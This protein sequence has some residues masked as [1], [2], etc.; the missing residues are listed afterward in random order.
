M[1]AP[2]IDGFVF[3]ADFGGDVEAFRFVDGEIRLSA[4][5]TVPIQLSGLTTSPTRDRILVT[6][7]EG[8]STIYTTVDLALDGAPFAQLGGVYVVG[9]HGFALS[10]STFGV[11]GITSAYDT[12]FTVPGSAMTAMLTPAA[13]SVPTVVGIRDGFVIVTATSAPS[14]DW[15]WLDSAGTPTGITRTDPF[16]CGFP[17]A[18]VDDTQDHA[19]VIWSGGASLIARVMDLTNRVWLAPQQT[20]AAQNG[21]FDAL[22]APSRGWL[23]SINVQGVNPTVIIITPSGTIGPTLFTVPEPAGYVR[24]FTVAGRTYVMWMTSATMPLLHVQ[25]LCV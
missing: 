23:V 8:S 11:A 13:N 14:C 17:G 20:I 3:G 22:Y 15:R 4:T 6:V 19:L 18:W 21:Q 7:F 9:D 1:F 2:T 25:Q 5:L 12:V 10:G 24:L 16:E